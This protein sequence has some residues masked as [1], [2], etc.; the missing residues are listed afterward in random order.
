[1]HVIAAKAVCFKEALSD[2]FKIYSKNVISNAKILSERLIKNGFKIF[3]GGTDTHLMLLDLRD[4]NITGKDA[5]ASLVRSNITC[6]KNGIP[7]DTQSPMITSGIR[8]G[9][10]HVLPE[11]LTNEF[12]L[13]GDLITKVLKGLSENGQ[14]NSKIEKE[15]QEV[16]DVCAAFLYIV[17]R[18]NINTNALSIL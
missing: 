10:P 8:L 6:N 18:Y 4:F 14:N 11:V 1:M 15:V 12:K 2:D 3:S 17:I 9:T 5:E 7:F 16:V 13:V